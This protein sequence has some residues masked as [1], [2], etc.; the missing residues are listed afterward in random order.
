MACDDGVF[1][2]ENCTAVIAHTPKQGGSS[3]WEKPKGRFG[4]GEKLGV[5]GLKA[6]VA[7]IF[8]QLAVLKFLV[9]E[10]FII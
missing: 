4:E 1:F 6:S 9:L 5:G 2:A 10:R 8:E 7:P 3:H